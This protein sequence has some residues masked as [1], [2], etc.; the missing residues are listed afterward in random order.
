MTEYKQK[1]ENLKAE[2][3]AF[4]LAQGQIN[5]AVQVIGGFT[6]DSMI[7]KKLP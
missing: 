7:T 3:E 2:I 1:S 6:G 5:N 4:N